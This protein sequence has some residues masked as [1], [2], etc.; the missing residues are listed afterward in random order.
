MGGSAQTM[1][2]SSTLFAVRCGTSLPGDRSGPDPGDQEPSANMAAEENS[3]IRTRTKDSYCFAQWNVRFYGQHGHWTP[4]YP[5]PASLG[6]CRAAMTFP[7]EKRR[8]VAH[9]LDEVF[10]RLYVY[11]MIPCPARPHPN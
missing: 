3:T 11:P 7:G 6:A 2:S 9:L 8:F 10:D 5:I 4:I 1:E